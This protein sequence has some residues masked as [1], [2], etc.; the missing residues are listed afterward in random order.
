[1]SEN[2]SPVAAPSAWTNTVNPPRSIARASPGSTTTPPSPACVIPS[3]PPRVSSCPV[4]RPPRD[5]RLPG[6]LLRCL[7]AC[8][9][10]PNERLH[11]RPGRR[12][13]RLGVLALDGRRC[14]P[15]HDDDHL[16]PGRDR[17]V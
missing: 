10:R 3:P 13:G 4:D 2:C 8:D 9:A 14:R 6:Y 15:T 5:T 12:E 16:T 17:T 11:P 7:A 1:M